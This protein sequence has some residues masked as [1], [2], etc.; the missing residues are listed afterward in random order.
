M[1]SRVTI[2]PVEPL[3]ASPGYVLSRRRRRALGTALDPVREDPHPTEA[4]GLELLW[5][6]HRA[7]APSTEWDSGSR[8]NAE[9]DHTRWI[10]VSYEVIDGDEVARPGNV[11]IPCDDECSS[12]KG[13]W[14]FTR[15]DFQSVIGEARTPV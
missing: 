1:A 15:V 5:C 14:P 6:G 3:D 10:G 4:G 11:G 12:R 8:V 7:I 9:G 2:L 13:A